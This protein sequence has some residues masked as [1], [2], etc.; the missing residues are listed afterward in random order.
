VKY[1]LVPSE[2]AVS[3][4][5]A[6]ITHLNLM[7]C[8]PLCIPASPTFLCAPPEESRLHVT[9]S[10]LDGQRFLVFSP[11]SLLELIKLSKSALNSAN[12][13]GAVVAFIST[14]IVNLLNNAL[15]VSVF[16]RLLG[17]QILRCASPHRHKKKQIRSK[18]Y[19]GYL[20]LLR[21]DLLKL[22]TVDELQLF[23]QFGR[24]CA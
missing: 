8:L 6:I 5:K 22:L 20:D 14:T 24:R 1:R 4:A 3:M 18:L 9:L 7:T 12:G 16:H 23:V 10:L 17:S 21:N 19:Y 13:D 2:E 11:C 15:S